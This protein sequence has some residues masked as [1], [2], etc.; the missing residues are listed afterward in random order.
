MGKKEG[1][2]G[3]TATSCAV[4]PAPAQGLVRVKRRR[5]WGA[6]LPRGCWWVS[7]PVCPF[8]CSL[9]PSYLLELLT[10]VRWVGGSAL[11]P[12]P[13]WA[14]PRQ[15]A[16]RLLLGAR[17]SLVPLLRR[18]GHPAPWE[19]LRSAWPVLARVA[20]I[21]A[22]FLFPSDP[23]NFTKGWPREWRG[24]NAGGWTVPTV[25]AGRAPRTQ[26]CHC[27]AIQHRAPWNLWTDDRREGHVR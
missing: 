5:P 4:S 6:S 25:A 26:T 15:V 21:I 24:G 3:T 17:T 1:R 8:A 13:P 7:E 22:N 10:Q 14:G 2:G 11:P 16:G 20:L 27:S 9:H 23:H 12:G 18:P 19:V